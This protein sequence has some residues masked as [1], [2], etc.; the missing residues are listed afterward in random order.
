MRARGPRQG[1][2]FD[3]LAKFKLA[4]NLLAKLK[5]NMLTNRDTDDQL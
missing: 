1:D 5:G 4:F 2:F 3:I